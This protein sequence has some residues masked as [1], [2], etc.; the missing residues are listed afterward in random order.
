MDLTIE[1]EN[2]LENRSL[3]GRINRIEREREEIEKLE[4][5]TENYLKTVASSSLGD[6]GFDSLNT[7]FDGTFDNLLKGANTLEEKFAVTFN[8]IS[9]VAKDAFSII[10]S[11]GQENFDAQFFRLEQQRDIAIAFAGESTTARA[12]IDR[13]YEE[14]RKEIQSRQAKAQKDQALFNIGVTTAQ[15][16]ISAYVSQLIPGDPTSVIRA[17]IAALIVSGIGAAQI[18]VVSSQKIPAFKD[19]VKD[20]S[21]GKAWL[22]DGGVS[23][24][25]V[26]PSGNVF[27]TPAEDTLYDLPKGTNIYKNEDVFLDNL[28]KELSINN[29]SPFG[30][31]SSGIL[32]NITHQGISKDDLRDVFSNEISKLNKTINNKEFH[33]TNFDENGMTNFIVKGNSRTQI[34]NSRR[35]G[36]GRQV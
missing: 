4:E 24:I 13:Q 7:F 32:S 19:G 30:S 1:S 12:E 3:Q 21:G 14:K 11:I 9:E 8:S 26:T 5:A 20:F 10:N 34:L 36:K 28:M 22:G 33:Q 31:L 23:E 15:G 35:R 25:G 6:L 27:R 29:I 18:A 2:L 16:A 17:Q